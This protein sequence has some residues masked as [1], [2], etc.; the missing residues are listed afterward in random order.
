MIRPH[1]NFLKFSILGF[2]VHFDQGVHND[3]EK[4]CCHGHLLALKCLLIGVLLHP[5]LCGIFL[6]FNLNKS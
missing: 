2:D 3:I 1:L 5:A 6:I 4:M